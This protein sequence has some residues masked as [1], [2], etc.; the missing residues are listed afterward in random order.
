MYIALLLGVIVVLLMTICILLYRRERND[1]DKEEKDLDQITEETRED[2]RQNSEE[3][4]SFQDVDE[5]A[6]EVRVSVLYN[7][8]SQRHSVVLQ[9]LQDLHSLHNV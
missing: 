2:N 4:H 8:P 9:T 1:S 7:V 3:H 5:P 6:E